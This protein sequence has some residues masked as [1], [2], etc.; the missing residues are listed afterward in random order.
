M[1][2]R[3]LAVA[4]CALACN[5][6]AAAEAGKVVLSDGARGGGT[7]RGAPFDHID[8]AWRAEVQRDLLRRTAQ[9]VADGRLKAARK[10]AGM[11]LQ[12]PVRL[13]AGHPDPSGW[14][15]P[16]FVDH[17]SSYPNKVRDWNCG[18]RTYDTAEGYNHRGTDI[19]PYPFRWLK[20]DRDENIVVAAAAGV[21]VRKDDGNFDRS[22]DRAHPQGGTNA[23]YVR[24]PDGSLAWYLHLKKHSLTARNVGDEVAAGEFIG[25]VGSS[26][27]STGPHLH[28]EIY[29]AAN[30][31]VDPFAGACNSRNAE[32]WWAQQPPYWN[33]AVLRMTVGPAVHQTN[34]CPEAE[35]T[36]L[37]N[38]VTLPATAMFTAFYRDL[39][40][41]DSATYQVLRPDG[42]VYA[43][44]NLVNTQQ[45]YLASYWGYQIDLP[46][47]EQAGEWTFRVDYAGVTNAIG[48]RVGGAEPT[49][50]DVVEFHHAGFDHYFVTGT[51][52]EA[53]A[54]DQGRP[55]GWA[56]TGAAFPGYVAGSA[57]QNPVCRFFWSPPPDTPSTHFYT[58]IASE[59]AIVK[60]KPDWT[61]EEDAYASIEPSAAGKCPANTRPLY[62]VYNNGQRGSPNHRYTT[63]WATVSAM[64]AQGWL[65]E[66]VVMCLP[67]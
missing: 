19:A 54:L 26:G 46:A 35:T 49:R 29:D 36:N 14:V 58:A 53:T 1:K 59:C 41:D 65:L 18:V 16:S 6:P 13:V 43:T 21:I 63:N 33:S 25:V 5:A 20:M 7:P 2:C 55:A 32:S 64:E 24:H 11:L 10:D 57:S 56:R 8:E 39:R 34:A 37:T 50:T 30:R 42:S 31:L 15:I 47:Q 45:D 27:A 9:M 61:F 12:W 22:C 23:V 60:A 4:A 38:Y 67:Q 52:A 40:K 3:T 48:F 28:F 44:R 17:D 62:R 51:A 66:G